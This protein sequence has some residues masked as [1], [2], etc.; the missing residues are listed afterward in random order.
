[1]KFNWGHG[2]TI[3]MVLFISYIL[4]LVFRMIGTDV[5]LETENYYAKELKFQE[6]IDKSKNYKQLDE[7][8]SVSLNKE[9]LIVVTLPQSKA[10]SGSLF[11]YR[12]SDKNLDAKI[13]FKSL[14]SKQAQLDVSKQPAGRYVLEIEWYQAG[15]GYFTKQNLSL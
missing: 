11:L 4:Y 13:N 3:A 1:M 8:V 7:K 14:N 2:L 12:P 15:K 9:G 10:D 6:Q 5:D